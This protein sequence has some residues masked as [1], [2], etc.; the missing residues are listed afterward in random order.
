MKFRL[1]AIALLY[2]ALFVVL[3]FDLNVWRPG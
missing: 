1:M 2:A 3:Y